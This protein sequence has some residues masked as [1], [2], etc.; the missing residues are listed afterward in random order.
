MKVNKVVLENSDTTAIAVDLTSDTATVNDVVAGKT[1]HLASGENAIGAMPEVKNYGPDI[2]NGTIAEII[3]TKGEINCVHRGCLAGQSNLSKLFLPK[4]ES[5]EYNAL[6]GCSALTELSLPQCF[7]ASSWAFNGCVSL[8]EVILPEL[9]RVNNSTFGGC[10]NL[11]KIEIPQCTWIDT[12]GFANCPNLADVKAPNCRAVYSYAFQA[13]SSLTYFEGSMAYWVNNGAFLNCYNLEK[14][15]GKIE[16]LE[17]RTFMNCSKLS[18]IDITRCTR[19]YS[20]E[21]YGCSSLKKL[22]FLNIGIPSSC[23][24]NCISLQE[25][26]TPYIAQNGLYNCSSLESLYVLSTLGNLGTG[27]LD[28]TPMSNS[29]YLGYY[30]SIYVRSSC[31]NDY[32]TATNWVAYAD[33]IT[34]MPSEIENKYVFASE[35][36][37][38][39][40]TEIP[41]NKLEVEYVLGSGFTSCYSLTSVFLSKCKYIG[42]SAFYGCPM[43][44]ISLPKCE[45][46][47]YYAFA[48][49]RFSS[50]DLPECEAIYGGMF[51]PYSN[52]ITYAS[53]PKC[54]NLGYG[55]FQ[56]ARLTSISL[57][58]CRNIEFSAFKGCTFL[59][60]VVLGTEHPYVC[61]VSSDVFYNTPMTN[62]S[63]LGYYGSIYVPDS[64]VSKYKVA[65][66]WSEY[67]ADRIT[68]IS[69]LPNE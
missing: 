52:P 43:T 63:Y 57:P 7:Y 33:R 34:N 68:G 54:K 31:V 46:I 49:A 22:D 32:R 62:S 65:P 61:S 53:L 29:D 59:S 51:G 18:A 13:C 67:Y 3:D 27:A 28:N 69:N 35:F 26:T 48:G 8:S 19:A 14:F 41:M 30:G 64:L 15:E 12:W 56:G 45:Y 21:F 11:K 66:I 16:L 38:S 42:S 44:E 47:S 60:T 23:C 50:L 25:V 6:Q 58:C 36:L 37:N 10:S 17:G 2:I 9:R 4:C 24:M 20:S 55:T 5:I 39:T 1:F 40:I